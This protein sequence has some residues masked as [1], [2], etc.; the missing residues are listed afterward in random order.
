[1]VRSFCKTRKPEESPTLPNTVRLQTTP[2]DTAFCRH[3]GRKTKYLFIGDSFEIEADRGLYRRALLASLN[4]LNSSDAIGFFNETYFTVVSVEPVTPDGTSP[5]GI[6]T[7][8][9]DFDETVYCIE[10]MDTGIFDVFLPD[11][12]LVSTLTRV[13]GRGVNLGNRNIQRITAVDPDPNDTITLS[14]GKK[15]IDLIILYIFI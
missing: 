6:R 4:K 1:M 9:Y 2:L 3:F 14:L 5:V 15:K 12:V 13:Q 10:D 7:G 8:C 11:N